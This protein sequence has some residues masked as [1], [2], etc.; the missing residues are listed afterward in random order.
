MAIEQ[1]ITAVA[2]SSSAWQCV[3][4]GLLVGGMR[5][6]MQ[7]VA[8]VSAARDARHVMRRAAVVIA[9]L[10]AGCSSDRPAPAIDAGPPPPTTD[11]PPGCPALPDPAKFDFFGETCTASPY[12]ANT[13]CHS[14]MSGDHGWCVGPMAGGTGVCRPLAY[15]SGRCPLCPAGTQRFAAGGAAY[16]D[17]G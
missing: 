3:S 14:D 7:Q 9:I 4:V 11:A 8:L 10:L 6:D 16:C 2:L 15:D 17:P 1:P 5:R 12:P 13:I